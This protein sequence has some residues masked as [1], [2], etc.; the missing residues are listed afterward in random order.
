MIIYQK[1]VRRITAIGLFTILLLAAGPSDEAAGRIFN[2]GGAGPIGL[3]D[4]ADLLVELNRGGEY[5]LR[6]YPPEHKR[7]D[8]GDYYSDYGLI[9]ST[10][11]WEPRVSLRDALTRTLEF[12]RAHLPYYV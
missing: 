6:T 9:R 11:G 1:H 7:I 8:I 4:L 12:Y 10:L 2:V 5:T 3:R